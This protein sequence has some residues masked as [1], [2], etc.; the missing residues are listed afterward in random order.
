MNEWTR[1]DLNPKPPRC[2][3]GDLPLIYEPVDAWMVRMGGIE[4]PVTGSQNRGREPLDYIP[5]NGWLALPAFQ[6]GWWAKLWM[7]MQEWMSGREK[8]RESSRGWTMVEETRSRL[9]MDVPPVSYWAG[10]AAAAGA[11]TVGGKASKEVL[12]AII[13]TIVMFRE[14]SIKVTNS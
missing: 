3:R 7:I 1:R 13:A 6:H 10:G 4:P 12:R 11:A 14:L 9:T 2:W 8:G 5:T